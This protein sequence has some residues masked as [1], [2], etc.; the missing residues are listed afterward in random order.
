[1]IGYRCVVVTVIFNNSRSDAVGDDVIGIVFEGRWKR[2]NYLWVP[3]D[4]GLIYVDQGGG[5]L[6]SGKNAR[7]WWR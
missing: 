2:L 3:N 6:K 5:F 1:M 4:D 7:C